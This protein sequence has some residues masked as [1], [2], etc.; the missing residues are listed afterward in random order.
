ME[1]LPQDLLLHSEPTFYLDWKG[2]VL[3]VLLAAVIAWQF[4]LDWKS[5]R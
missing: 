2:V 4:W 1:E 3:G 5:S